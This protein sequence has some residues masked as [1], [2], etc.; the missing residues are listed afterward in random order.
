M[1]NRDWQDLL[2]ISYPFCSHLS[3]LLLLQRW[4]WALRGVPGS[5]QGELREHS[6]FHPPWGQLSK[7]FHRCWMQSS[8]KGATRWWEPQT[9]VFGMCRSEWRGSSKST[10]VSIN[11]NISIRLT[12]KH[13]VPNALEV[14]KN[15]LCCFK[16]ISF[17]SFL[18]SCFYNKIEGSVEMEGSFTWSLPKV[19]SSAW[20]FP[21]YFWDILQK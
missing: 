2:G 20:V 11:I 21:V 19:F 15:A 1:Q 6:H 4:K 7:D 17:W 13:A 5:G 14:S 3:N 12:W 8:G 10:F 9:W 18:D 16:D